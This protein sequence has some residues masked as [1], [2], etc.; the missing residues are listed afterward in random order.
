[1]SRLSDRERQAAY[2]PP[3]KVDTVS[4]QT[5]WGRRVLVHRL[6]K[7]RFDAACRAAQLASDWWPQRIDDFP[8]RDNSGLRRRRIRDG[9]SWSLHS[10]GLAFDFFD[11]PFPEAV[12][13]WGPANAPDEA[14]GQA[15]EEYGF[16]WGARWKRQD[17][18]HIEWAG[19]PP[20]GHREDDHMDARQESKLDQVLEHL[21]RVR[22][23]ADRELDVSPKHGGTGDPGGLRMLVG[24]INHRQIEEGK[25]PTKAA[26]A[27]AEIYGKQAARALRD[28]LI[29]ILRD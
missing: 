26:E 1:M 16:T 13:V 25:N 11:R 21:S 14:F 28:E 4:Y 17:W 29:R 3:G 7:H 12:D 18:P 22:Q 5:P 27:Y 10:Y 23:L 2:G 24:D 8:P 15:F 20:N 9:D 6:L 19:P